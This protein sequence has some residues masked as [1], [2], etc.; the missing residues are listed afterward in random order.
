MRLARTAKLIVTCPIIALAVTA[1]DTHPAGPLVR[2]SD[3][4]VQLNQTIGAGGR[5]DTTSTAPAQHGDG[6]TITVV[7]NDTVPVIK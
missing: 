2:P 5:S 7:E 6:S 3:G 4:G 1:C